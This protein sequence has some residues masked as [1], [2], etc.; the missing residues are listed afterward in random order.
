MAVYLS[1]RSVFTSVL[2][3]SFNG[4]VLQIICLSTSFSIVRSVL[5][6]DR[7]INRHTVRSKQYL[8]VFKEFRENEY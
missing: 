6:S 7:E 5:H 4:A 2:Y 3:F 1:L 8:V